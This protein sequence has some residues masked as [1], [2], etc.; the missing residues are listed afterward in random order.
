MSKQDF[1]ESA[2][3]V[4]RF[5]QLAQEEIERGDRKGATVRWRQAHPGKV[6]I[7]WFKSGF[8]R[9]YVEGLGLR[10]HQSAR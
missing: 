6:H 5:M 2:Y 1:Q 8:M 9:R 7:P 4:A 10:L 3:A